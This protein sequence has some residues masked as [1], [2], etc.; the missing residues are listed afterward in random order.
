MSRVLLMHDELSIFR[1]KIAEMPKF[2]SAFF[3]LLLLLFGCGDPV[4]DQINAQIPETER[5]LSQL[6]DAINSDQVK[7]VSLIKQYANQLK[8]SKPELTQIIDEF[9]KDATAQGPIY[10]SLLGRI[11]TVKNNPAI[12]ATAQDRFD[13]LVNIYQAADPSLFS[14]ALSDP[15]NVLADMSDGVLPRVN[16]ISK[17][18]SL[19]ANGA[20]DFG[21]G[22]QLIGNPAYGS[23]QTDSSGMSFWAWYGMYSMIDNLFDSRRRVYYNDWGRNR[24]YSYYHDY[25]R[26][27]YSSPQQLSKQTSLENRT[28]KTFNNGQQKFT[29]AYAKNRTGGSSLSSQS[30]SAQTSADRFR[31][32]TTN[33]SRYAS[34]ARNK[35]KNASFRNS[36]TSTSRGFSRG[37]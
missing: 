32:N 26:T 25:G 23:W 14:D 15:L 5:R 6:A 17:E 4:V 21:I 30:Q 8:R 18:R 3:A 13:E 24:S 29:S 37:K 34:T 22:E 7:N 2:H 27:R 33:Q 36:R 19:N 10:Q 9:A 28:R 12:F 1:D 11:D 16:A 31:K 35:N 20:Q